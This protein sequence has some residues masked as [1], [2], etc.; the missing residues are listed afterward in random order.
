MLQHGSPHGGGTWLLQ[1]APVLHQMVKAWR[2]LVQL[3]R[4]QPKDSDKTKTETE[5]VLS[6]A[7]LLQGLE[8]LGT[9]LPGF[10]YDIK[11]FSMIMD[12]AV[13][14]S[15]PGQE[16]QTADTFMA[17]IRNKATAENK[18]ALYPN[19]VT[20]NQYFSYVKYS[21]RRGGGGVAGGDR[22]TD[23]WTR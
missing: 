13:Q 7:A 16:L 6:P 8:K 4:H 14:Q 22:A 11:T 5:N 12:V 9:Q 10:S 2:N 19:V 20:W 3:Q 23:T 18:P 1:P 17:R 21:R 15:L